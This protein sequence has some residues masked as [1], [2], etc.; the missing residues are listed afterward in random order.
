MFKDCIY[1]Y[2]SSDEKKVAC[3][4]NTALIPAA[5]A[6]TIHSISHAQNVSSI[7][8]EYKMDRVVFAPQQGYCY[9][10][11]N[12]NYVLLGGFLNFSNSHCF[13]MAG[14]QLHVEVLT[15]RTV[16]SQRYDR[17]NSKLDICSLMLFSKQAHS[18]AF[19]SQWGDISIRCD[20][21]LQVYFSMLSLCPRKKSEIKTLPVVISCWMP[22][23]EILA[24]LIGLP[25]LSDTIPFIPRWTWKRKAKIDRS[26]WS[27]H[28][29]TTSEY[30]THVGSKQ[31]LRGLIHYRGP[32]VLI[33]L[34]ITSMLISQKQQYL[35][36]ESWWK[37]RIEQVLSWVR[38]AVMHCN[39]GPSTVQMSG[40]SW[41]NHS[42]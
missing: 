3:L 8:Q 22:L 19:T 32:W 2:C 30:S 18:W 42:I 41:Y 23:T 16:S 36:G 10:P 15:A 1:L 39:E 27:T 26:H 7:F 12:M 38:H 6:T 34:L 13:L 14:W 4:S 29:W 5:K 40:I 21:T 35:L 20:K 28:I 17:L 25:N 31:L 11:P 9:I 24:F 33:S 37:G